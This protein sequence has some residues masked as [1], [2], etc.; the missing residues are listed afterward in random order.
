MVNEQ[1]Q[2]CNELRPNLETAA[3]IVL[4]QVGPGPMVKMDSSCRKEKA[5]SS[6]L[7]HSIPSYS[8]YSN[9]FQEGF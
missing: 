1:F 7:F 2:A 4:D 9:G 6:I 8:S 3:E 5:V